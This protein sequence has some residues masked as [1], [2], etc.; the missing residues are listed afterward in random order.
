VNPVKNVVLFTIDALRRDVFGCYGGDTGLT[1]FL[2]SLSSRAAIFTQAHSIAPFTQASF[3]GLLT[4][5]YPFDFPK[6]QKLSTGRTLISEALK[7]KG[8]TTAA[9][10]SNP[11]LSAYFGWNRSWDTFYDSMQEEVDDL[12]PY[13]KG[14][15]L[16]TKVESWLE[17]HVRVQEYQPFFLWVHYMDVHEPY[18][19]TARYLKQVDPSIGLSNQ[20]MFRLFQEVILKRDASDAKTVDLLHQL[21]RA[22]VLEIDDYAKELFQILERH[23]VLADS[24]VIIT[25]DHGDEFGEHGGLS[26]DGKFYSEL[27]HVPL[28]IINPPEGAG[29][30]CDTLVSGLDIPPTAMNLFGLEPHES[31]QGQTLF[32]FSAY[33]ESGCYGEAIGKLSHKVK[34]TDRPAFYYRQGTLKVIYRQEEEHWELYDLEADPEEL[35]N[36]I[37]DS[38]KAEAMREKLQPRISRA[39]NYT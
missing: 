10:H 29:E 7:V 32:P 28:L 30:T 18:V 33:R 31:F 13:I 9:F 21:Y 23:G 14:N 27:V 24:T 5:S 37:A 22:H 4:S 34:E 6:S 2:D 12:S 19:P 25:T 36:I 20:E 35:Q 3:P 17:G 16:N 8:I 39:I 38:P 26:H 15:V 1:P 11:Y